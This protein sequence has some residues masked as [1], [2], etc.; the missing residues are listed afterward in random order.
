MTIRLCEALQSI[1][2]AT[3]GKGG[4][5]LA[6]RLSMQT[7]RKTILR[8]IMDLPPIPGGTVVLLGIDDFSFR[9]GQWF[10]TILE[11]DGSVYE[12]FVSTLPSPAFT[13][14]DMLDLSLHRGSFE[15]VLADQD[16][17]QPSPMGVSASRT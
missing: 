9:R 10:G 7:S 12:L 17:E 2:L 15:A 3:C 14:S 16:V 6:E 8:R 13:A 5:R 11:R 4:A 1:G